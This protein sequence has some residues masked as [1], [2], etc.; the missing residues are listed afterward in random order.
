MVMVILL[1]HL[2]TFAVSFIYLLWSLYC[3]RQQRKRQLHERIAFMLWSAV[4]PLEEG[5]VPVEAV[6]A[7]SL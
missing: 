1:P 5:A 6:E 4:Q 7:G 2:P 3:R